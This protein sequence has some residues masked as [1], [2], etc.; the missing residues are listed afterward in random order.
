MSVSPLWFFLGFFC[1]LI[2][3][4]RYYVRLWRIR[5]RKLLLKFQADMRNS[6]EEAKKW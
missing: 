6:F 1:A 4:N 3:A 5:Q 2:P